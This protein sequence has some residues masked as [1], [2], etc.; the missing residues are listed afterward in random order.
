MLNLLLVLNHRCNFSCS[1]CLCKKESISISYKAAVLA[2]DVYFEA[3]R[4]KKDYFVK[5]CG[6]EPLL[7][8]GLLKRI[9]FYSRKKADRFGKKVLF[10]VSTNA[11]LLDAKKIIFFRNSK[12][13]ELFISLDGKES[14]QKKNRIY[15]KK[16]GS[17]RNILDHRL[18]LISSPKIHI[19]MVIAPNKSHVLFENFL[20]IVRMGFRK[21]NFLPAYFVV[22]SSK[23]A[24]AL[25][26]QF[27]KIAIFLKKKGQA[28][29]IHIVN[30]DTSGYMPL[31]NTGIIVDCNGDVFLNNIFLLNHFSKFR[32]SLKVGNILAAH[33]DKILHCGFSRI[34]SLMKQH[35]SPDIYQSTY[36]VDNVLTEF[37]YNLNNEKS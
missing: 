26:E 20:F 10:Q 15:N 18:S 6:G 35:L 21:I 32:D 16:I 7:D 1:Y 30:C 14:T 37:V 28:S 34:D 17:F 13:I 23:E 11:S 4:S 2:I 33:F 25:Q 24:K 12:D 29:K 3:H 31:I 8:Y 5:F 19:N 36:R 22:W 27:T 9:I